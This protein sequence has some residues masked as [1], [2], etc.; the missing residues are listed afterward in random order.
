MGLRAPLTFAGA[1]DLRGQLSAAFQLDL[2]A[3]VSFDHP[4]IDDMA[5]FIQ[6]ELEDAGRC[7]PDCLPGAGREERPELAG[8][9]VTEQRTLAGGVAPA[10]AEPDAGH[11]GEELELV[12][13]DDEVLVVPD[14]EVPAQGL[15]TDAA[16][17]PAQSSHPTKQAVCIMS[18]GG[19]FVGGSDD[20]SSLS[21]FWTTL[22]DGV[23]LV[24]RIPLQVW[25]PGA[26]VLPGVCAG[27]VMSA[28]PPAPATRSPLSPG[29][30]GQPNRPASP[31]PP[32]PP[33][34]PF[35]TQPNPRAE[36]GHRGGLQPAAASPPRPDV[37]A[38][39]HFPAG[40]GR[41]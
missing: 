21:G 20:A 12:V 19:R 37:R 29:E 35:Q 3:T 17:V 30:G 31:L 26:G 15:Y 33:C 16:L 4:T 28:G 32:P 13:L 38:A 25:G 39:R 8:E 41:V 40:C 10:H 34:T 27:S 5:V 11:E 9:V 7:T 14:D 24:G 36:V 18:A 1:V 23:D 22:R 2:P 6:A